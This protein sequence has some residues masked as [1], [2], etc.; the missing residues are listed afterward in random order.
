MQLNINQILAEKAPDK[1]FPRFVVKF[2]EKIVH[3]DGLNQL[4]AEGEGM[5]SIDFCQHVCRFFDLKFT[6]KN[7]ENLPA[8]NGKKYIFVSNHPLGG[9][10]GVILGYILGKH[11]DGKVKIPANSIL[12][13]VESLRDMFVSVNK[14]GSPSREDLKSV[15]ELYKSDNQ[16]F[17]FPAGAVSRKT[18]GVISD[19]EWKKSFISAAIKERRDVVPIYFEGKNSNF[20]YNLANLRKFLGIKLNVEMLFFADE[21]FKQRGS[22]FTVTVGQPISYI[23]FDKSKAHNEWAEFVKAEAYKLKSMF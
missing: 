11:Y 21:L 1:H 15:V 8:N 22:H 18:K 12:M 6:L 4:F 13:Y 20:F 7:E 2:L 19:L 14:F 23:I 5:T 10:D 16:I 9:L 17:T 3:Q